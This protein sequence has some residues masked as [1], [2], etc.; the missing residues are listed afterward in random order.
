MPVLCACTWPECNQASVTAQYFRRIIVILSM[1][2]IILVCCFLFSAVSALAKGKDS[3]VYYSLKAAENE[4]K[5]T[6]PDFV[7]AE[8]DAARRAACWT[9]FRSFDT[10]LQKPESFDYAWD[11][12]RNRTVSIITSTD[13][14]VRLYTWNLVLTNGDFKNFGY[15]QVKK[16]KKVELYPLLDT[17]KKFN[18]DL[19]DAELE[20]AEWM[21][22]LYYGIR[23]FKQR[24]KKMYLLFGFDGSTINSNKAMLDVLWFSKEGPM[25]GAPAFR[26]SD[27]DPSAECR[28]V[29]EFHND[30][31]MLL[32]YE[33]F[34]KVIVA[35]K[36]T[37]AFQEAAGNY[38][39]YI[40]SGD[41]DVYALSKKGTWVRSEMKDFD[42]GQGEKPKGPV[43]RPNPDDD[44]QNK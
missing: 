21:G 12:L 11:S 15:L 3:A 28:V 25:F 43:Q 2:F 38:Y 42:M 20:S 24:G 30:V 37:P 8:T 17:L 44:P 1:R 4:L 33:D 32:R 31:R 9:L 10:L 27:A 14:K 41:Y 26:Q 18:K 23:E 19:L 40:P 36:L 6:V 22:A 5:N 16:K 35:D 29:Y 39:Y 7:G 13:G 34:K